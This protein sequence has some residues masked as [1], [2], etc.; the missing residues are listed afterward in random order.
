M[1]LSATVLNDGFLIKANAGGC[2]GGEMCRQG[3]RQTRRGRAVENT[4]CCGGAFNVRHADRH[5][6]RGSSKVKCTR[7]YFACL[8]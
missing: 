4:T 7:L 5:G 2:L 1:L 6:C 8:G 3:D